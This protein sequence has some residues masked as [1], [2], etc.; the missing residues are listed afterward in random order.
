MKIQ[1]GRHSEIFGTS[2]A[3]LKLRTGEQAK[4]TATATYADDTERDVSKAAV[5][6]SSTFGSKKTKVGVTVTG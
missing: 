3:A 6:T 1:G 4:L 2:E 5:W